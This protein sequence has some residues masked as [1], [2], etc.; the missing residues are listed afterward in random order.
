MKFRYLLA[1]A[2]DTPKS[3]PSE[4]TLIGHSERVIRAADV[5]A[6]L[7][8]SDMVR[9]MDDT[10]LAD[11]WREALRYS[12]WLHDLGKGNDHFQRMVRNK[13]IRQGIRHETLGLVVIHDYLL[14]CLMER[15]SRFPSW[16]AGAVLATICGHHLKFP[17]RKDR[18]GSDTE[19]CFLGSHEDMSSLLRIG[20]ERF[21]LSSFPVLT[22]QSFQLGPFGIEERVTNIR[23]RL[24]TDGLNDHRLFVACLKAALLCADAA[25]SAIPAEKDLKAWLRDRLW[26][27]L[28]KEGLADVVNQRLRGKPPRP[29]QEAV[30]KAPSNTVLLT[31]G[32]GSGKTAAAYLWAA[33][34]AAGRRLFVCYPTTG[35]ASEGFAGYLNDPDFEAILIHS[36]S[37]VDYRLL[38]N[39][40]EPTRSEKELR[41]LQ[42]EALDTWPIPATVCTAHTVLGLM[43][44]VRRGLYAW[45]AIVRGALVFDEIH[46][47]SPKLFAHLLRFLEAFPQLPVLLMTATLPDSRRHAMESACTGRGGFIEVQGPHE[48]EVAPRYTLSIS[49][50]DRA[51]TVAAEI[52]ADGGKVLWI[53]N[54]VARA[55]A[56]AQ[57]AKTNLPVEPF[58]S[59]YRYRDRLARQRRVVDGFQSEAPGM[60]AVTTQVAEVSL[61]IS[62]DLLITE[63][64]PVP[65]L[66]QRL[67]RLNRHEDMPSE[68]KPALFLRPDNARP[69]LEKDNEDRFWHHVE[70]WLSLVADGEAKSQRDLA[71]A[72]SRIPSWEETGPGDFHCHWIDDPWRSESGKESL[73]E[74]GYTIELIREEDIEEGHA[75]ELAIPMPF[76]RGKSWEKW[77]THGR[78]LVAPAGTIHYD[79]IWG[80]TY[81]RAELDPW[82]I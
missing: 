36:R 31:A 27:S 55:I 3:P 5:F 74:P 1:K 63:Y 13:G 82:I 59:R 9:L 48:R 18:P 21:A 69:Y 12:A 47:Y 57:R 75:I 30:Q 4:A 72:F 35:T 24:D 19:V 6:E 70:G 44:N 81:G 22:D 15:W 58:H 54:T 39:L 16:F 77:P 37:R 17:D 33:E 43:Q 51:W 66:I 61:D 62:A 11:N 56:I 28:T 45:P 60:L 7:L 68:P 32:C 65:S 78:Y 14:P 71:A 46:A 20:H 8:L 25:A 76:P 50:E 41:A 38:D 23:R 52:I 2:A 26:T 29:F 49:Q 53:C 10:V 34:H 73:M 40:P 67:G 64:A 42:L 80:A 79:P